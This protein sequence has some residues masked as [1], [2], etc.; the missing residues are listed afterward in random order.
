MYRFQI[1]RR[2]TLRGYRYFWRM[3]SIRN[4]KIIATGGEGFY[5]LGDVEAIVGKIQLNAALADVEIDQ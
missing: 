4:G 1:Y 2:L 3:R 5:N